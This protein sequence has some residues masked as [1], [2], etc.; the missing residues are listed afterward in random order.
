V[1]GAGLPAQAQVA[2][3]IDVGGGVVIDVGPGGAT[4]VPMIEI[5]ADCVVRNGKGMTVWFGYRNNFDFRRHIDIGADNVVAVGGAA[6]ANSGQVTQFL[7]G[8]TRRAFAANYLVRSTATWS[9]MSPLFD[10]GTGN[11]TD[12]TVVRTASSDGAPSCEAGVQTASATAQITNF[13]RQGTNPE[14]YSLAKPV[15][16]PIYDRRDA[17]GNLVDAY[18]SFSIEGVRSACSGG[19]RPLTPLVLW[20][21]GGPTNRNDGYFLAR[22]T[23]TPGYSAPIGVT[24]TDSNEIH[25]FARTFI[26]V[27]RVV[28]PQAATDFSG[29]DAALAALYPTPKG[30]S[31]EKVV[32]DVFG[33]C[34]TN[35]RVVTSQNPLWVDAQGA[36]VNLFTTTDQAT[37]STRLPVF[38]RAGRPV[39]PLTDCD[40]PVGGI[41]PGGSYR[42]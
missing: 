21:F 15:V 28:D 27:R 23:T 5:F 17:S 2:P 14:Y 39:A 40:V 11:P 12:A 6:Q 20:G 1:V 24:R 4:T 19:G 30:L 33:R 29:G 9:I 32:A 38:C 42:R 35:G 26:G 25:S 31:S 18:V 41:G 8:E 22:L 37:Q 3:P 10:K 36:P 34:L 13:I 7:V 16:K